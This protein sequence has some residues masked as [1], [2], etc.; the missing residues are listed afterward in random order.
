MV[1]DL[2]LFIL[3]YF[4]N[5]NSCHMPELNV[6]RIWTYLLFLPSFLV[7][8]SLSIVFAAIT[9]KWGSEAKI[10]AAMLIG[11]FFAELTMVISA[12]GIVAFIKSRPK[13]PILKT[14]GLLNIVI[15][16]TAGISGYTIFML[17]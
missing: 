9:F 8:L 14:F 16:I 6:S 1:T 3:G 15:L 11:L 12:L 2:T 10:P 13:A 5:N 4:S 17:L 7:V